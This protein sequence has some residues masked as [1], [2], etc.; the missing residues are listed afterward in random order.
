MPALTTAALV[1][2]GL[3][4]AQGVAG[5]VG[6]AVAARRERDR[7]DEELA[8]LARNRGLTAAE[9]R[10]FEAAATAEQAGVERRTQAQAAEQ[11]AAQTAMGGAVSG[12]DIFLREQAA[13]QA[14]TG[15]RIASARQLQEAELARRA[16][17]AAKE[18]QLRGLRGQ[19]E[20]ARVAGVTQ[21]ITAGL[22]GGQVLA[23][24]ALGQAKLE[25]QRAY[26]LRLKQ[27]ELA[28][29]GDEEVRTSAGGAPNPYRD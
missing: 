24:E 2:G 14:R 10:R 17:T 9:R 26:D 6:G 15:A 23:E 16:E 22:A 5:G 12:R 18:A 11:L 13:Q 29:L 19:A 3:A 25:E 21:A 4:A 28:E 20:A 8:R 27:A 7:L 1:L